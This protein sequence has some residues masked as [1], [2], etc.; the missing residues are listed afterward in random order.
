MPDEDEQTSIAISHGGRV[1]ATGGMS[2]R[3]YLWQY[4]SLDLIEVREGHSS[5][6]PVTSL[7]FSKQD[8]QLY[9]TS[10][11]GTLLVWSMES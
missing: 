11:D 5:N 4:P 7:T 10:M 2:G 1:I 6:L 3:I 8:D 9:S